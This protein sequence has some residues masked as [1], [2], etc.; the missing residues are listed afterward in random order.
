MIRIA[1]FGPPGSGKSTL[2]KE[3]AKRLRRRILEASETVIVPL[4]SLKRFPKKERLFELLKNRAQGRSKKNHAVT[5]EEA[6][7]LF[8]TIKSTYAPDAIAEALHEIVNGRN[9]ACVIL[10]GLRG[11]ENARY[12]RLHN[13]FV[14]YL[15]A[16]KEELVRRLCDDRGY[17]KQHA[18]T[19]LGKEQEMYKTTKIKEVADLVI[20]TSTSNIRQATH[21]LITAIIRRYQM[22]KRCVNS[23]KNPAIT[24]DKSGYCNICNAFLK[25]YDPT[26]LKKELGFLNTFK[27]TG[28]GVHDVLVGI[29]GGK[30]STATLFTINRMGFTPLAVTFNLGYLPAT[31]IP[32]AKATAKLLNTDHEV[33]D[34]RGYI[35]KI[36]VE[37][38]KKTVKLYEE[39]FT[40][41][42][43]KKFQKAY[44]VGRTHYSVRCTH[45]P[46]FVRSC[47][48]CRRMVIRAYYAETLKRGARA[49]VLGINEWTNLSAAQEGKRYK[50]SGV[51]K[52]QPTK[53]KPAVFVFHLP[54]L[55]Q[56]T[57]KETK[58]ILEKIGWTPPKGEDFI[59]S[60][61][62][63]C[64]YA[65]STE[66]MAKRLLEFHPDSTR[67]AREVT[68]GFITKKQAL[69]ALGKIHPYKYTPRQVLERAKVLNPE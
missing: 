30:D 37:S 14:V 20:N 28:K 3:I 25:K 46:I 58:K 57:S 61:S 40:L 27:G 35:R 4:A 36:D 19:E 50:V 21:V 54:F 39:P 65:R 23:G 66:R 15:T 12:C 51:R 59:E 56:R 2:A 44:A 53:N 38:Y 32:R 69:A 45:S 67:L 47:Q 52:L 7:R 62:N 29:S 5:R 55:L 24:F 43:K 64:L 49:I 60:N 17:T 33:I 8:S 18:K 16:S 10:S 1:F 13:D 63:S 22:C 42:T 9:D 48:L 6:M 34:I 11:L 31:T 41:E 68:V 26:Q